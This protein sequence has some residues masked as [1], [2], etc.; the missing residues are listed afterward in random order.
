MA[1]NLKT[2][3]LADLAELDTLDQEALLAR[4]YERLMSY[5]YC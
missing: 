5:G 4:R 1:E 3:I 2:Q